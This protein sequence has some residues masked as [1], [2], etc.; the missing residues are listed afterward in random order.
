MMGGRYRSTCCT[1]SPKHKCCAHAPRCLQALRP[2][3]HLQ[4]SRLELGPVHFLARLWVGLHPHITRQAAA[5]P[6]HLALLRPLLAPL[7]LE[8]AVLYSTKALHPFQEG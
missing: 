6:S 2:C 7:A 4:E 8:Q 1:S 5:A 3:L